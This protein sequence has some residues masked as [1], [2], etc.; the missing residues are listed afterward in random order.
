M[1][2]A[3]IRPYQPEDHSAVMHLL[4]LLTPRYFAPKEIADFEH[5]LNKEREQYFVLVIADQIVGCGGINFENEYTLGKI[6]WDL[7]HPNHHCK[8]YG[9]HLLEYRLHLLRNTSSVQKIIVRTSQH[10]FRFYEKSGFT[11][12]EIQPNYWAEGYD[13]YLMELIS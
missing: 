10:A 11:V 7:I 4:Q 3:I 6:S 2:A 8:G 12:K 9:R 13:M 1:N 5:Y